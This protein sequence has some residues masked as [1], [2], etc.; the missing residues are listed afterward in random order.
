MGWT[1]QG[2]AVAYVK[3]DNITPAIGTHVPPT[4]K[5]EVV[6]RIRSAAAIAALIVLSA[7]GC[8]GES[9][10]TPS[11]ETALAAGQQ[12]DVIVNDECEN[13]PDRIA[14]ARFS[15]YGEAPGPTD[16]LLG[17]ISPDADNTF[18]FMPE[19]VGIL[20]S[21]S[22][23]DKQMIYDS[24]VTAEADAE[25]AGIKYNQGWLVGYGD[26]NSPQYCNVVAQYERM[27][28]FANN[29]HWSLTPG[30]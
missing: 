29:G 9:E 24:R 30:G 6:K 22:P 21:L 19:G 28:H 15:W 27:P 16:D 1:S 12:S 14:F 2:R 7:S 5:D 23:A 11:S 10:T 17:I 18:L 4:D 26:A 20:R 13:R 3:T 25:D 8:S